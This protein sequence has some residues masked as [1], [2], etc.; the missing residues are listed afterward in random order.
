MGGTSSQ[1]SIL[2][3]LINFQAINFIIMASA[4]TDV[5]PKAPSSPRKRTMEEAGIEGPTEAELASKKA[6][7]IDGTAQKPVQT[8]VE[9]EKQQKV[10]SS[11]DEVAKKD[12]DKVK[13]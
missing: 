4:A 9:D 1:Q 13:A 8:V 11:K 7:G 10:E 5:R 3:A 6:K 2:S 12:D